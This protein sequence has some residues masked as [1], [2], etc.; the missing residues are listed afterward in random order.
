MLLPRLEVAEPKYYFLPHTPLRHRVPISLPK[1]CTL[2]DDSSS[3]SN[4]DFHSDTTSGSSLTSCSADYVSS[5]CAPPHA[6]PTC[7]TPHDMRPKGR[8]GK[9]DA[10]HAHERGSVHHYTWCT[11]E[12]DPSFRFREGDNPMPAARESSIQ[13]DDLPLLQVGELWPMLLEDVCVAP[14]AA[15]KSAN[16]TV[17]AQIVN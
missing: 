14:D 11:T 6:S 8:A 7:G 3:S 9:R 12:R 13:E 2:D 16:P 10:L 15:C 1:P 17:H 4:S 5:G